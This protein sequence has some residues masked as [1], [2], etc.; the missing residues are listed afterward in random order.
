MHLY[1]FY[2]NKNIKVELTYIFP[3]L[4]CI[5]MICIIIIYNF[6][7][8]FYIENSLLKYLNYYL[9][10]HINYY[11]MWVQILMLFLTKVNCFQIKYFL[12]LEQI[13]NCSIL[14]F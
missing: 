1:L 2:I 11:I 3:T 13:F 4:N 5:Y 10:S 8:L 6:F 14:M 12:T 7:N 9:L